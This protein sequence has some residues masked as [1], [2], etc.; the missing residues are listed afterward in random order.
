MELWGCCSAILEAY[1]KP[2]GIRLPNTQPKGKEL[3]KLYLKISL[4][5]LL[6][7]LKEVIFEFYFVFKPMGVQLPNARAR[8]LCWHLY[9]KNEKRV[10][11]ETVMWDELYLKLNKI[12]LFC[13]FVS[14]YWRTVALKREARRN[15]RMLLWVMLLV[16]IA[17]FSSYFEQRKDKRFFLKM[18]ANVEINRRIKRK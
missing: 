1:F 18:A 3:E 6:V 4:W 10:I 14:E 16:G 17:L 7:I 15:K 5:F 2:M 11:S 8:G 13:S 9:W 12:L